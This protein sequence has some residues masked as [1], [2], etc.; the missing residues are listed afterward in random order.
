MRQSRRLFTATAF[1]AI[2]C[3]MARLAVAQSPAEPL[4]PEVAAYTRKV[5]ALEQE[6]AAASQ[7]RDQVEALQEQVDRLAGRQPVAA[8]VQTEEAYVSAES[9][10]A[11]P[12]FAAAGSCTGGTGCTGCPHCMGHDGYGLAGNSLVGSYNYNF[13]GGYLQLQ[14]RD[15]DFTFQIQNQL[16]LD[17][18]FYSL[19]NA[20]TLEKGFNVPFYR[21]YFMGNFLEKWEYL[22]SVQQSLGSFNI[23]DVY[24]GYLFNEE[25]N[26]RVGHYLSPFLYEYWAFSPAWEPVITNSP[27]FQLAGKRQTGVMLWGRLFDNV[28]QYQVGAFNGPTGAYFDLDRHVDGMGEVTWTPFKPD[29]GS[30]L[31][32]LGIGFSV[33]NGVQEYVLSS[34]SD[35][36]FPSGNGEPTLNQNFVN[37]SGVP[38]FTYNDTIAA[39][40]N[41]T[42]IAPHLFWFGQFS[43][44]AEYLHWTRALTDGTTNI[45][46]EIDAYYVNAS[47][48]LTGEEYKGDGLLGY[49]TI[50]PL[51]DYGA[52]ELVSQ[53][54]QIELGPQ[55][56]TP[57]FAEPGQDATRMQ[58]LMAGVNW[59]PNRYVRISFDYVNVWTN[60][61][62][63]VG[64]GQFADNYGIWWGRVGAFF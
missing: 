9:P 32:S 23:L 38:W 25:L 17:G 10:L 47:Y 1:F 43:L 61:A 7:L 6:V 50:E 56:L 51:H 30:P 16:T 5:E 22:A 35:F 48:F 27:L 18:T 41:R 45:T 36:N 40:G 49:T 2:A 34:G 52:W 63:D 54:S 3:G 60:K 58:Q 46:E 33:Q 14:S 19:D 62:V 15:K 24:A 29:E 53:F 57:G 12:P 44:L 11:F 31:Q 20:N 8:G 37:S 4:S 13:G 64:A 26:I 21:L 59:W 39:N 42:K 55:S 28:V